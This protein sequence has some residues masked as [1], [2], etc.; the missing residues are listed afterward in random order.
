M[1][2]ICCLFVLLTA[3]FSQTSGQGSGSV[4][5]FSN[6]GFVSSVQMSGTAAWHYGSD[7]QSGSVTLQANANGKSRLELRL[8]RGTRVET[9]NAFTDADR[10]CTWSGF[11]GVEHSTAS[12]NC[13][14]S[15]VWFLPHIT[16]QAGAAAPDVVACSQISAD[17][18]IVRLHCERH[19][20]GARADQTDKLLAQVSAVELDVDAATGFAQSLLFNA[21]PDTDAGTDIPTEIQFSDYRTVQGVMIPFHIQKFVNHALVLDLQISDVTVSFGASAAGPSA[22]AVQ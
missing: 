1:R 21:H 15:T 14:L 22:S 20:G 18:K 8:N 11:D 6:A 13:W 10:T 5:A 9:Q 3:A 17:G 12:H 7:E 16:M 2:K 19:P 4:I